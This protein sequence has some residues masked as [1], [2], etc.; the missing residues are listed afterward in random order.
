MQVRRIGLQWHY[1]GKAED[2]RTGLQLCFFFLMGFEQK[3][4][5]QIA[6]MLHGLDP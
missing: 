3:Q 5:N 1:A 6:W 2:L 4:T